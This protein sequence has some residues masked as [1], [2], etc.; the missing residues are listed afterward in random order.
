MLLLVEQ[1]M[2]SFSELIV[3]VEGPTEQKFVKE[4]LSP[5]LWKHRVVAKPIIISK[6]GQKGGDVKFDRVIKDIKLHLKQRHDT[7]L[8]LMID[9]YGIK[10]EWPGYT[11]AR[12]QSSPI[13]KAQ[14]IIDGTRAKIQEL[15]E[16][17]RPD[18]RFIPYFS[19]HEFEALLFS[20]VNVLANS[21]NTKDIKIKKILEECG[22]PENINDSPDTSPSKRLEN[23]SGFFRKT[24]TGI[25]I[26]REIGI[27]NMRKSCPNFDNWIATLEKIPVR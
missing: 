1:I 10:D 12:Q 7:Y 13:L 22:E 6:P 8:T 2:S 4:I 17:Y 24:I 26:A 18:I 21:L 20:D 14:F 3:L 11:V 16:E 19:M 25:A 9:F 23:L 27:E 15:C 5:F